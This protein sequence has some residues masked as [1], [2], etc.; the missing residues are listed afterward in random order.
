MAITMKIYV[1]V[2]IIVNFY[3]NYILLI[4][5]AAILKH[6]Y[7]KLRFVFAALA[8]SAYG[9]VIFLPEFSAILEFAIHI[10]AG[11]VITFIAFGFKSIKCFIKNAL[12]FI[13]ISIVFAG[14]MYLFFTLI[15]P[16]GMY[17]K[18][19]T[20]Y[21]DISLGVLAVSTLVCFAVVS[22]VSKIIEKRSPTN[23]IYKIFI[24]YHGNIVEGRGLAD[25]GNNLKEPFSDLPVF[26]A[27][28]ET[29][30]S[31]MPKYIADY[32]NNSQADTYSEKIRFITCST[33]SGT[34]LLPAFKVKNIELSSFKNKF[35]IKE[36]YIAVT[37]NKILNNEFEFIF[38]SVIL[39]E[40]AETFEK[41]GNS[42]KKIFAENKRTI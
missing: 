3:V 39:D 2:L 30:K 28:S 6:N 40:E 33:I 16:Y 9:L 12:T 14:L 31:I 4:T 32:V 18:N 27:D 8:G 38:S 22:I 35:N 37:K 41:S 19:G 11:T 34:E 29:V 17:Y 1:D 7:K 15:K 42:I 23:M 13:G 20:V 5:Q 25:S 36:A 21:F 24:N 26:L 10:A